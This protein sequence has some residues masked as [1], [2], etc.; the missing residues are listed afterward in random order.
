MESVQESLVG[1]WQPERLFT[2]Q[3]SRE[4]Y[5]TYLQ[6]IVAC[7]QETETALSEFEPR[8]DPI[9]KPLPPDRKRNRNVCSRPVLVSSFAS[10]PTLF[11][12]L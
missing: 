8:V 7:D 12:E 3:P 9:D 10:P 4:L 6:Q 2:L 1:A 11:I 5:R